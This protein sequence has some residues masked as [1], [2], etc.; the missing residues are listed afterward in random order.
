MSNS[1]RTPCASSRVDPIYIALTALIIIASGN[2]LATQKCVSANGTVTYSDQL[3]PAE[4]KSKSIGDDDTVPGAQVKYYE[5]EGKDFPALPGGSHGSTTW[6]V[7]YRYT[8]RTESSAC[9][10]DS[11]TTKLEGTMTIPNWA[12]AGSAPSGAQARWSRYISALRTH[13]MGHM[14]IG[15]KFEIAVKNSLMKMRAASCG[16]LEGESR[17]RFDALLE[18]YRRIERDY[19][20]QTRHG[21][22]QGAYLQ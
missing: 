11:V 6:S 15:R 14:Q 16:E 7:S 3:C 1:K 18:D 17:R 8:A 10:I 21:A 19:D 12:G 4:S 20:T 9:V 13:E 2:A 5:V 22:T